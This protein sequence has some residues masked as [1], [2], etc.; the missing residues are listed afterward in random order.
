VIQTTQEQGQSIVFCRCFFNLSIDAAA[1]S[2]R[3]D[4]YTKQLHESSISD[5]NRVAKEVHE[6]KAARSLMCVLADAS[7]NER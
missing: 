2:L 4:K 5:L 3:A 1:N 7:E 6:K